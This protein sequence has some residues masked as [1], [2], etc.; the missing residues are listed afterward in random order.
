MMHRPGFDT[1]PEM[2]PEE[3]PV[4]ECNI[5]RGH[6]ERDSRQAEE[7]A[8]TIDEIKRELDANI[9]RQARL[10]RRLDELSAMPLGRAL[11]TRHWLKAML[12]SVELLM[13]HE[14]ML[15]EKQDVNVHGSIA[16]VLK[17]RLDF[18]QRSFLGAN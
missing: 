6:R 12:A 8:A 2:G 18:V 9:P 4:D 13:R 10:L 1:P 7:I 3:I 16:T 11:S 15:V 14:G 17:E 5:A